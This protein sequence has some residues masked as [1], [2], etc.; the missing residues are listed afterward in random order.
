MDARL[1][2]GDVEPMTPGW[3]EIDNLLSPADRREV[4]RLVNIR[5]RGLE[6]GMTQEATDELLRQL[7]REHP[8]RPERKP[9]GL[10][11]AI[12]VQPWP[13]ERYELRKRA[14]FAEAQVDR[15]TR[16]MRVPW[17]DFAWW[18]LVGV[19]VGGMA[20]VMVIS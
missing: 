3:L 14:E 19:I 18:F 8:G 7:A 13:R 16:V 12:P 5:K 1:V 11:V 4:K 10:E 9:V 17:T 15:L 20:V 2:R 6:S